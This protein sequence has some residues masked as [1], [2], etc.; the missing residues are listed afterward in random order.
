MPFSRLVEM[1]TI[2]RIRHDFLFPGIV[3][4]VTAFQVSKYLG[5]PYPVYHIPFISEFTLLMFLKTVLIG[6]LCG[7]AAWIFV[8]L[9]QTTKRLFAR[10]QKRYSLWPPLLPF[11]GGIL[12]ALLIMV[13]PSKYF[14]L[15]LPI[16]DDGGGIVWSRFS[17]VRDRGQRRRLFDHRASHRLSSPTS[18]FQQILLAFRP[19]VFARRPGKSPPLLRSSALVAKATTSSRP[20]QETTSRSRKITAL[21]VPSRSR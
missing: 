4:G 1:L 20:A 16:M 5:V 2:G 6:I 13:I 17:L 19:G 8:E 12:L 14:S 3:A 21:R 18:C 15:S 9:I 11:F 7:A 10:L